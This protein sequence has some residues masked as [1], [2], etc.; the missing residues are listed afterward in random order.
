MKKIDETKMLMEKNWYD[1]RTRHGF[2]HLFKDLGIKASLEIR[3]EQGLVV[4][5][6][7]KRFFQRKA[8]YIRAVAAAEEY[9]F[10]HVPA[11]LWIVFKKMGGY[12]RCF[13]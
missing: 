8:D 7:K 5:D 4:I 10:L 2:V 3:H 11:T 9:V 6:T 13:N 1:L 12:N